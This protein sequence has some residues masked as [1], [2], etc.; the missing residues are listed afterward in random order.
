MKIPPFPIP[1]SLP[2]LS[3]YPTTNS[4]S[5]L[6]RIVRHKQQEVVHMRRQQS[7][8]EIVQW[9]EDMPICQ[10]FA[11]ALCLKSD[12][13]N[14]GFPS[15]RPSLI[16]EIK[17]ASPSKGVIRENFNPVTI[18][19][20][21][22]QGGATCLSVLTDSAFFQGS[23]ANLWEVRRRV[24]LPLLCKEFIIDAYQV[25]LARVAGADAVL[26]IAAILPEDKGQRLLSLIH[27]LGMQSLV[28]VHTLAEL[29]RVMNWL[30]LDMVGINNRNLEDFRI[31]ISNTQR[32]LAARREQLDRQKIPV[33]S[34]SGLDSPTALSMVSKAGASGV[35]VGES[36]LKKPDLEQAVK[37]LLE[38][39]KK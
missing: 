6:T 33:I 16:A 24:A 9:A 8:E 31:D 10:D 27:S 7:F 11:R 29:D 21:Y 2:R 1:L 18:A 32:L 4:H 37:I 12:K 17:K 23:F 26:L 14:S 25:Y 22:E 3:N 28:E 15:S 38:F 13:S 36:L 35:L 30:P 34:E 19:R 20:A 39:P 5:I